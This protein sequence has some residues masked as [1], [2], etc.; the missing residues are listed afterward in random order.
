M[1]I[2]E[3]NIALVKLLRSWESGQLSDK[4][5]V[6]HEAEEI[7]DRLMESGFL[8]TGGEF[9]GIAGLVD[10]VLVQL[11]NAHWQ[12]VLPEDIGI[13]LELLESKEDEVSIAIE[14]YDNYWNSLDYS[15]RKDRVKKY[16]YGE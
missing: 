2:V 10:S 13:M 15:K 4:W 3:A 16:W 6:Q 12:H 5:N 7:E 1:T 8:K 9:N 14:K 11:C